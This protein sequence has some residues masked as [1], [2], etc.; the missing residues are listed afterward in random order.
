MSKATINDLVPKNT[1]RR[2][3]KLGRKKPYTDIGIR[4]KECVRCGE[5]ASQQWRVCS[6]SLWRPV[7]LV[8]DTALNMLVL[9]FMNHPAADELMAAYE[10]LMSDTPITEVTE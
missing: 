4:R 1:R 10:D 7:C 6:D 8:C 9:K 2:W 3:A 5:P